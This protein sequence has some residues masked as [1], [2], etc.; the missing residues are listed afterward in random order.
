MTDVNPRGTNTDYRRYPLGTLVR[1]G[2]QATLT[3]VREFAQPI[4]EVWRSVTD[5]EKTRL[6]WAE[7]E[8]D[9]RVGG[10]F[11]LRWLNG[12]DDELEW[13]PGEITAL[14]APTL[15]EHTNSVHGLL[16]WEFEPIDGGTRLTFTNVVI[17][18]EAANVSRSLAGWHAHLDHLA[19]AM[20]GREPRWDTWHEAQLESW[21]Q[22]QAGYQAAYGIP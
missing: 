9:L 13:W 8:I 17:P 2:D 3:F 16:R 11:N 15:V 1:E 18:G 4:D 10:R 12:G 5:P 21:R 14:Q 19:E 7:S 22:S 20:E 6:W